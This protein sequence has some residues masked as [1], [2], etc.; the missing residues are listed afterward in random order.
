MGWTLDAFSAPPPLTPNELFPHIQKLRAFAV[1]KKLDM[2]DALDEYTGAGY[3]KNIGIMD[4]ARFKSVLGLLFGGELTQPILQSICAHYGTNGL[5][6][7]GIDYCSVRWKQFAIDFDE[8][9]VV[10]EEEME[11]DPELMAALRAMRTEATQKRLDMTD[12]FEEYSGTIQEKNTGIM[13]KNRFRST[14]GVLFRGRLI[15]D[16]LN[17]ICIQYG[18]G[19]PDPRERGSYMKVKWKQVRASQ[20]QS[21][22]LTRSS[23]PPAALGAA[24]VLTP[25]SPG[26]ATAR[27]SL[28]S[29]SITSLRRRRHRCPTRRPRSSRQ[30]AT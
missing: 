5:D 1:N 4:T 23:H 15:P 17:A 9:P 24:T 20:S 11:T 26:S 8:V 19:D 14:M 13:G 10:E 22:D 3:E 18:T 16:V 21:A 6:A 2:T 27:R 25:R 7:G 29:T 12:A 30:C 28:P